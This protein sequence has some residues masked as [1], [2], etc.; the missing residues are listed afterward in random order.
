VVL[1]AALAATTTATLGA[2]A[3][4]EGVRGGSGAAPDDGAT[5]GSRGDQDLVRALCGASAAAAR[6]DVDGAGVA[7]A[8]VHTRL[9]DLAAAAAGDADPDRRAAAARLL[10]AKQRVEA[11]LEAHAPAADVGPRLRT[12]AATVAAV[13]GEPVPTSCA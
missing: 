2:C 13:V 6:G 8:D 4:D 12:L 9:H 1:A 3:R 11:G 5:S 7:F 10:E